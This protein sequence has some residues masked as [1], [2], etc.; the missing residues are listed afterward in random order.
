[1]WRAAHSLF[2][3]RLSAMEYSV[4]EGIEVSDAVANAFQYLCFV[5]A[6]FGEAVGIRYIKTVK[7]I[8]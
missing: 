3:S 6:A 8:L 2:L 5:V 7:D 4:S 1:M